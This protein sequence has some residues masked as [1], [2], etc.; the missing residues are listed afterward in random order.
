MGNTRQRSVTVTP[1]FITMR[2]ES[3]HSLWYREQMA[4]L[5][6]CYWTAEDYWTSINFFYV[7]FTFNGPRS[8]TSRNVSR[9]HWYITVYLHVN[10]RGGAFSYQSMCTLRP[11]GWH[12]GRPWRENKALFYCLMLIYHHWPDLN[13]WC[14]PHIYICTRS[15]Y[16]WI[17]RMYL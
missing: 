17:E 13:R 7:V 14:E 6:L 9:T 1:G 8:E 15:I 4:L 5:K 2:P 3:V 11:Q 16:F 10:V 12:C